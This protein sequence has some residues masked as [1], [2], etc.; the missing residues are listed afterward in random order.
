[1]QSAIHGFA[2][3]KELGGVR[4]QLYPERMPSG[5]PKLKFRG[6]LH[7]SDVVD[8]WCMPFMG[9]DKSVMTRTQRSFY[10]D[11][12]HRSPGR[13]L[14]VFEHHTVSNL[15]FQASPAELLRPV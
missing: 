5:K 9:S 4:K 14:N 11:K 3:A 8:H 7:H 12:G 6:N 10:H 15:H 2:H 13:L 1:M